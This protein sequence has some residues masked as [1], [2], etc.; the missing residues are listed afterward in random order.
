MSKYAELFN[1]L[2]KKQES[3]TLSPSLLSFL[4]NEVQ[5]YL[6]THDIV[7]ENCLEIGCGTQSLLEVWPILGNEISKTAV[8]C[9]LVAIKKA[10]T[11]FPQSEV[12]YIVAD[13]ANNELLSF[14]SGALRDLVP[15]DIILDGHALHF[16]KDKSDRAMAFKN[17]YNLLRADGVFV[18]ESTI[19]TNSFQA[20]DSFHLPYA[21]E[22][23]D[24][25][26][27][28][29]FEIKIFIVKPGLHL[30]SY[31]DGVVERFEVVTFIA[32]KK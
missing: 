11:H 28:A 21:H 16:I 8:D 23:E 30:E 2:H 20:S 9:S 31:E 6:I 4:K 22:L 1:Q 5:P 15:Q 13:I 3:F 12:S 19:R 26:L 17:I 25:I 29:G 7:L 27:K 24:E 18:A 10:K 32:R 14:P